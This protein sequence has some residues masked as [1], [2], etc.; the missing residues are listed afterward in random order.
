[1]DTKSRTRT[2]VA[3]AL[4]VAT[5]VTVMFALS[6]VYGLAAEYGGG[7][8]ASFAFWVVAPP[9][10]LAALAVLTFPRAS[11]RSRVAVVLG[12]AVVMVA[13]GLAAA[14]VGDDVKRDRLA[15]GSRGFACNGPNALMPV[16]AEVDRTWH[17]LPRLA[18]IYGPIEASASHCVAGVAGDGNRTF[19]EYTD[20]FRQLDGWRVKVDQPQRFVMLRDG[21]RVTVLLDGA[22]DRLTTIEVSVTG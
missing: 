17:M 2:G 6:V 21:V 19:P 14:A 4:G 7:S 13:G 1:M 12:T 8:F 3:I 11:A 20:A 18:P 16:E 5:C 10:L 9:V 22:P 15:Q